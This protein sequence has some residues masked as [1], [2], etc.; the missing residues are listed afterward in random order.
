[1]GVLEG[2]VAVITGSSRGLGLGIAEAYAREGAALVLSGRSQASLDTAVKTLKATGARVIGVPTDVTVPAQMEALAA[3][4]VAE[5]GRFDIWVNNAGMS[6]TYGRTLDMSPEAFT[7]VVHTNIG[8]VYTGSL[9]A[10]RQFLEQGG[11]KLINLLGRGEDKPVAFQNS[12][13][14]SKAWVR[15]FT[16][17]L[18]G[19][20]KDTQPGIGI[21]AFN[22]GLVDTEMLRQVD[23]IEGFEKKVAPLSTVM[24]LWAEPASVPAEKALW[25]ASP[26]TDGK[27]GLYVNVLGRRKVFGGLFKE[28]GRRIARRPAPD[29]SL[30]ITSVPPYQGSAAGGHKH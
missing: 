7:Q 16:L 30:T 17:A 11:G 15:S 12:Y 23:V 5:F 26:A 13:A 27:T 14:S 3:A 29:T 10:V 8:G 18:A 28:A 6:G 1:M 22:P 25:L 24:R 20:Y 9:I 2:K 21:Y 4:A 19:E